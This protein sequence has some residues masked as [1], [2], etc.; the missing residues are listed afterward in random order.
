[1]KKFPHLTGQIKNRV[2]KEQP[3]TFLDK[4]EEEVSIIIYN[5]GYYSVNGRSKDG[6]RTSLLNEKELTNE[7]KSWIRKL[8]KFKF[9][10]EL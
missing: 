4:K 8:K 2:I 1:M 9:L 10:K 5:D 3:Y 7:M 6:L